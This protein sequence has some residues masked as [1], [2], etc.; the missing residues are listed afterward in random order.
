MAAWAERPRAARGRARLG[1]A[2]LVSGVPALV[3]CAV[4]IWTVVLLPAPGAHS[5]RGVTA[6][7]TVTS[8]AAPASPSALM[9]MRSDQAGGVADR[10]HQRDST[11]SGRRL[12]SVRPSGSSRTSLASASPA[13]G[14]SP[15]FT[16]SSGA[17]ASRAPSTPR[18]ASAPP[19]PAATTNVPAAASKPTTSIGLVWG[20]AAALVYLRAHAN[21]TYLLEC[22]GYALG[23]QAMTCSHI[24]GICPGVNEI[25]IAMP[26]PAAYQNEAWNSWHIYTGPYDPY[27]S[28]G[29]PT[30]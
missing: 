6:P 2:G 24:A 3:G 19:A 18:S 20:C 21:P 7:T 16:A 1:R 10:F 28:C 9:E 4:L 30:G 14:A 25:V 5:P 13:S 23:H 27:G 29:Y 17:H 11:V 12:R 22:P 26:C 8:G 15:A